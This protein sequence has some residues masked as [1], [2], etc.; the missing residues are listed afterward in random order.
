MLLGIG[1]ASEVLELSVPEASWSVRVELDISRQASAD[2]RRQSRL[3]FHQRV[4]GNS[5]WRWLG[6]YWSPS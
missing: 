5:N 6:A 2:K 3:L 1:H 4:C